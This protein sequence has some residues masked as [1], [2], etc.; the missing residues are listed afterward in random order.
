MS[1]DSRAVSRR[2]KVHV[3]Q[4]ALKTSCSRPQSR[5]A[6]DEVLPVQTVAGRRTIGTVHSSPRAERPELALSSV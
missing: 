4:Q 6:N 1:S 3:A 5:Q 2:R